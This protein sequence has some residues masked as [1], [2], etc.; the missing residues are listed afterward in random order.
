MSQLNDKFNS[1]FDTLRSGYS[2]DNFEQGIDEVTTDCCCYWDD[3]F[4]VIRDA[5]SA[6]IE[7]A[8]EYLEDIGYS[9]VSY[10]DYSKRVAE[11]ILHQMLTEAYLDMKASYEHMEKEGIQ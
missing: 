11:T 1:L 4:G 8:D 10:F 6:Q 3:Y 7:A 2:F 9:H 5:S